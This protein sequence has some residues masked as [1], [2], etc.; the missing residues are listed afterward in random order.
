[1]EIVLKADKNVCEISGWQ[2]NTGEVNARTL[3]IEMCEEM[4]SCAMAFVTFKLQDGTVYESLV[5]DGKANIPTIDKDQFIEVGVYSA[6]IEN[7][8]CV[9]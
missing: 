3:N 4:C 8:K 6:D 5:T 2:S 9:K 7:D 1:M